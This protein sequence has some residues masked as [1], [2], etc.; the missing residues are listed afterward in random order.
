MEKF[1]RF[2]DRATGVNPFTPRYNSTAASRIV[3]GFF[4]PIRVVLAVLVFALILLVQPLTMLLRSVGLAAL[5]VALP[6]PLLVYLH[7]TL[8]GLLFHV[9]L[10][11]SW[12]PAKPSASAFDLNPTLAGEGTAAGKKIKATDDTSGT[13]K[14]GDVI[15]ANLQ[16]PL[17]ALVLEALYPTGTS[18]FQYVFPQF[19]QD[20]E[21]K[22]VS[23]TPVV[24]Y[25]KIAAMNYIFSGCASEVTQKQLE[26]AGASAIANFNLDVSGLQAIAKKQG[27]VLVLFAEGTPT[28][29]RGLL[30]M[31]CVRCESTLHLVGLSYTSPNVTLPLASDFFSFVYR[32]SSGLGV[33]GMFSGLTTCRVTQVRPSSIPPP[34]S[35]FSTMW[36]EEVRTVLS[37]GISARDRAQPCLAL[38]SGSLIEKQAFYEH[39]EATMKH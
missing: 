35:V 25:G 12:Y 30:Q 27:A 5:S 10:D 24:K 19:Q 21:T 1:K 3:N 23:L 33:L 26:V 17:D 36:S 29:G 37:K 31:P 8:L 14:P 18:A 39:W 7:R 2:T 13:P 6:G 11:R 15:V 32:A 9:V 20:S 28:N 4:L 38:Q 34:Q 22:K 16:S